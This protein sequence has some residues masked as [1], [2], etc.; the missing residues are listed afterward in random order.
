MLLLN[1]FSWVAKRN[2]TDITCYAHV[3]YLCKILNITNSLSTL[4]TF[5][6][7]AHR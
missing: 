7:H 5:L 1:Y 2:K 3:T 4:L 6:V